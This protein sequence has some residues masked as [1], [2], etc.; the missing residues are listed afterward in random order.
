MELHV[1]QIV[2]VIVPSRC[3]YND[4]ITLRTHNHLNFRYRVCF[5][6]GVPWHWGK[7]RVW[8]HSEKLTWHDKNIQPLYHYNI[9]TTAK[10]FIHFFTSE[11]FVRTKVQIGKKIRADLEHF[12]GKKFKHSK[13]QYQSFTFIFEIGFQKPGIYL[14]HQFIGHKQTSNS[15]I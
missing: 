4:C 7:Y 1:I 8:I 11:N 10:E 9:F 15:C 5:E 13:L 3:H 2:R 14:L 6:Q 12:E